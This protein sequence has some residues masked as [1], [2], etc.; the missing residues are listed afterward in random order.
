YF[1]SGVMVF[2]LLLTGI[3]YHVLERKH[4]LPASDFAASARAR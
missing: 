4:V 3:V 1:L 2:G